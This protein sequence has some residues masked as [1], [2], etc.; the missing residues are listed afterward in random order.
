MIRNFNIYVNPT[1]G[2]I[3]STEGDASFYL[4]DNNQITV[5][6][7]TQEELLIS[8]SGNVPGEG[9]Y[10]SELIKDNNN[11][12][13]KDKDMDT[14]LQKVGTVNCNIHI[15]NT[16]GER[17][18]TLPFQ[19]VSKL[20][21]DREGSTIV[22]P[23]TAITLEDFYVAYAAIQNLNIQKIEEAV[24]VVE[25]LDIQKIEEAI[26]IVD[27]LNGKV[28]ELDQTIAN[29]KKTD[30]ELAATLTVIK[31]ML[32]SGA[33]NGEKGDTGEVGPMGPQGPQGIQGP[34]GPMGPQGPAG[35]DGTMSFE[36]LTPEQKASLKGDKGEKGDKGD[37]GDIGPVGPQGPAGPQGIQGLQGIQGEKGNTGATGPEGPMGPKG[38]TGETGPQGEQGPI[39]PQGPAGSDYILTSSDKT[40]IANQVYAMFTNA[41]EVQY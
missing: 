19:M 8:I 18:T 15:S 35:K 30:A 31:E 27:S 41:E 4:G 5:I 6:P 33:L 3:V 9:T 20:A 16:N 36:D 24:A 1:L 12:I 10:I 39:G 28:E 32:E 25:S 40:E 34:I 38:D 37:Q 2:S 22:T 13:L 21:Y 7:D 29:A 23:T 14:F 11:Y 26:R 17:L